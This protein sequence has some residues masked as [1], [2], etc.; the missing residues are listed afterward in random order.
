MKALTEGEEA[1]WT[2]N[3]LEGSSVKGRRG[4]DSCFEEFRVG[5]CVH[6]H[7]H[8][9]TRTHIHGRYLYILHIHTLMHIYICKKICTFCMYARYL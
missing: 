3:V 8:P 4:K 7:P 5:L 6:T 2:D 1:T 9:H